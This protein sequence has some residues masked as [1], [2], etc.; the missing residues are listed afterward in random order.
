MKQYKISVIVPVYNKE[1]YLKECIDSI[2]RQ[3]YKKLELILVDDGSRDGSGAIC[4]SYAKNDERVTVLHRENGGPTAACVAGM[5]AATGDYYMFVDSD[6]YV[7]A[8]ML[9]EM[10]ALLVGTRGEVICCNHVLEKKKKTVPVYSAAAPGIYV[11]EEL[12]RE[13]KS[14]LI[15][16][17]QKAFPLSRCMKLC[18]RSIFEGSEA[19]LDYDIRF[20]DDCHF[21]Y[22]AMLSASR[23]VIMRD[24][25]F[26]HYRYVEGSIVHRYDAGIFASVE[27]LMASLTKT[28]RDKQ[29]PE[30]DRMLAREH[31][32]MLLYVLKNELRNPDRNYKKK[33]REVFC[34]PK[35][36][37][38]FENTSL[39]IRDRFNALLY[40]GTQYPESGVIGILRVMLKV[41]D[42]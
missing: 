11:G 10:A 40:L 36:I 32:Y 12:D 15:G 22:P 38:L 31:C 34:D 4:D 14:R 2:L 21:M 17:E 16:Q 24:A 6:D 8:S 18:E 39:P 5:E 42:R 23:I 1:A 3:T 29:M 19:C 37:E 35:I 26:Y 41:H 20:G 9:E 25:L 33:I 13:I 7:E 28:V 27:K 30:G